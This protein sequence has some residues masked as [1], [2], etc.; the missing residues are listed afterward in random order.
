MSGEARAP[1]PLPD[2]PD[3]AHKG[4]AGR[5][6]LVCGSEAMPGAAIF[7]A[8]AAM[9]AG[10]GTVT[11]V[12][13]G[14]TLAQALPAAVPE[15]MLLDLSKTRDLYAGRLPGPIV[16]RD[17][18]ARLVG[19]GLGQGGRTLTLVRTL[20]ES[21]FAGGLILDADGLTSLGTNVDL[22]AEHA[23]SLVIT[24]H[25]GEARRLL[26]RE[27]SADAEDRRAAALELAKRSGGVCVLKGRR[28]VVANAEGREWTN[29][30]GNSGMATAGAGDVL[31]G[32]VAAYVGWLRSAGKKSD[33]DLFECV[34]AATRVHGL[35]GDLASR[36]R[37]RRGVIASDIIEHL[38]LAQRDWLS[39][40]L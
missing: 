32:I 18:H 23:G 2:L 3:D 21:T 13:F 38:P 33:H 8:R 25:P 26:G 17:D 20:V 39:G 31:A 1:R 40:A 7:S 28:S 36:A 14:P 29:D 30:T 15:A 10:A 35:A 37:G 9:R 6:L 11:L 16:T 24:P 34:C 19:P 4:D 12:A 22:L 27:V 5:L